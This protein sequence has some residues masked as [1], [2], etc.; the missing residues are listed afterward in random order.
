MNEQERTNFDAPALKAACRAAWGG[1]GAPAAF[2]D[3][4]SR[5][6]AGADVGSAPRILRLAPLWPLASA[7]MV[8]LVLGAVAWRVAEGPVR[9]RA[10]VAQVTPLPVSLAES[11]VATHDRC[12]AKR[13]AHPMRSDGVS[14]ASVERQ[15]EERVG[16]PVFAKAL[17]GRWEF[18]GAAVCPVGDV[19]AAHLIFVDGRRV[20]SVFS[21]P[22]DRLPGKHAYTDARRGHPIAAFKTDNGTYCVVGCENV[23]RTPGEVE[24]ICDIVRARMSAVAAAPARPRV[25][26]AELV[27]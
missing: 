7:A 1:E 16:C 23:G 5:F 20:V 19:S 22:A 15:L 24:R 8:S 18:D 10:V 26:V 25:T 11:L 14:F 6:V 21:L 12:S 4:L 17:P 2:K 13:H 27:R 3:H 9:G